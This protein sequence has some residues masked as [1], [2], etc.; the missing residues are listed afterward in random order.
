MSYYLLRTARDFVATNMANVGHSD[1]A[2][3]TTCDRWT[4]RHL[5]NH[6]IATTEALGRMSRGEPIG[7]EDIAP[8]TTAERG[9]LGGDPVAA[10]HRVSDPLVRMYQGVSSSERLTCTL[11]RLPRPPTPLFVSLCLLEWSVHGWDIGRSTGRAVRIPEP[12]AETVLPFASQLGGGVPHQ[13]PSFA[14]PT[15]S[16]PHASADERLLTFLGRE[17]RQQ[18][19]TTT[20]LGDNT[21]VPIFR[22]EDR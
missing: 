12:L 10:F 21:A 16:P 22:E 4:L 2:G 14:T 13:L 11:L 18:G 9:Y 15:D 20:E 17:P 5:V 7:P 19:E 3:N 6:V 8:D 1:T